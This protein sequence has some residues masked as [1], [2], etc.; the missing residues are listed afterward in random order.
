M[1][2]RR[3]LPYQWHTKGIVL[4]GSLFNCSIYPCQSAT[5]TAGNMDVECQS[6]RDL[7]KHRSNWPP[8]GHV[9]KPRPRGAVRRRAQRP[10]VWSQ[11]GLHR[12][13]H[14]HTVQRSQKDAIG[15]RCFQAVSRHP[16]STQVPRLHRISGYFYTCLF[17]TDSCTPTDSF[18]A[19]TLLLYSWFIGLR[20]KRI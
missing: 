6:G 20:I 4:D 19:F 14:R 2:R 12:G 9:D 11:E 16:H 5:V 7:R 18:S 17:P 3:A 1:R 13:T 8:R 15:S 10:Q